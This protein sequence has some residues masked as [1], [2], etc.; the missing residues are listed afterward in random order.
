MSLACDETLSRDKYTAMSR[1]VPEGWLEYKALGDVI[2]GTKIVA[3]KVPLKETVTNNLEPDQRFTPKMLLEA[4]PRMKYVID[5]TNTHRY[6]DQRELTDAGLKYLKIM[7]PGRLI[8]PIEL[9][10]RFFK[11]VED[12]TANS[13]ADELIGVHCTHGVNRTGYFICRYLI[14]QL[15]WENQAAMTAFQEAR[16]HPVERDI[17]INDLKTIPKGKKLDTKEINLES[18]SMPVRGHK[19]IPK[20]VNPMGPMGPPGP[21]G[22]HPPR[23]GFP[24]GRP[25]PPPHLDHFGYG[26]PA[27]NPPMPL[28]PPRPPRPLRPPMSPVP[29]RPPMPP[30]LGVSYGPRPLRYGPPPGRGFPSLGFPPRMPHGPPRMPMPP[31]PPRL[32]GPPGPLGPPGPMGPL[33]GP[34]GPPG[35]GPRL[36]QRGPP[37][38]MPP[39]MKGLYQY[40]QQHKKKQLMRNGNGVRNGQTVKRKKPAEMAIHVPRLHGEQDFTVD[41]FEENLTTAVVSLVPT[42]PAT[43]ATG[44]PKRRNK[45]R[46]NN[47]ANRGK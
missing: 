2:K 8:P 20:R 30:P 47:R 31:C 4:I 13:E 1:S 35:P 34:M 40:Q 11:A 3:F 29:P 25:F 9:V 21:P 23:R 6:Y 26:P 17:Y 33:P 7:V 14:Q 39:M 24:N 18:S 36:S 38:E 32:P 12:F 22:F 10:K 16:G 42:V 37:Q 41:T 43:L 28:R 15:G 46:F 27:F 44:G 45:G 19:R 5:L